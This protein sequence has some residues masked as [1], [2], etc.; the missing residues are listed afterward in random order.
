MNS[1]KYRDVPG[2]PGY[3]VGVSVDGKVVVESNKKKGNWID[4]S[5]GEWRQMKVS[6]HKRGEYMLVTLIHEGK[7]T[8]FMLHRLVL[9]CFVGPP[10]KGKPLA[11]HDDDNKMNNHPDNLYWGTHAQN[12]RDAIRNGKVT[13]GEINGC[14][15]LSEDQVEEIIRLRA[16]EG[17]G[18]RRLARQFRTGHTN[19]QHILSGKTWKHLDRPERNEEVATQGD[20]IKGTKNPAVVLAEKQVLEIVEMWKTGF[21]SQQ[22]IADEHKVHQTLISA[23]IRGKTWSHLT[24]IERK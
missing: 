19:I 10:P 22:M 11:L 6:K 5:I 17:V 14:V 3:R 7:Y 23:I 24:G 20:T 21:Y 18:S 15:R 9:L 2:F 16:E 1:F 13:K 8:T 12:M 4:K